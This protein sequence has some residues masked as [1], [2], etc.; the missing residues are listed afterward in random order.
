MLFTAVAAAVL[1][2]VS[3][4]RAADPTELVYKGWPPGAYTEECAQ[5]WGADGDG[6]PYM[7]PRTALTA[8]TYSYGGTCNNALVLAA[9]KIYAR[10]ETRHSDGTVCHSAYAYNGAGTSFAVTAQVSTSGCG[11]PTQFCII[12][13]YYRTGVT[14]Y[15]AQNPGWA[16]CSII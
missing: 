8:A 4:V 7:Q 10:I 14:P 11:T 13:R 16:N 3:P 1:G 6:A 9:N 5:V 15:P 12:G 2:P